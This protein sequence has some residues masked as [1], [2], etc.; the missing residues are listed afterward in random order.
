MTL[1][2]CGDFNSNPERATFTLLTKGAV[3]SGEEIEKSTYYLF[4][5]KLFFLLFKLILVNKEGFTV[6]HPYKLT[7]AYGT[8]EFTNYTGG[9]KGCLDYIFFEQE[10]LRKLQEVPIPD[11]DILSKDTAL[12]SYCFPSDHVAL[13]VDFKFRT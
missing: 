10:N 1:I 13:V 7:S 8:P 11:E 4:L 12:P 2:F 6:S 9:Y 3:N 5:V